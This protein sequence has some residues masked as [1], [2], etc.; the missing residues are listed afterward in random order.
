LVQ[1]LDLI[2]K[3]LDDNDTF[4]VFTSP[5]THEFKTIGIDL[6]RYLVNE[7]KSP[8]VY[9]CIDKPYSSIKRVL[10]KEEID[11]KIIIF[12]DTVTLMSGTQ[13]KD[14]KCV[15]I[16]SPENLTDIS[17]AI[18]QAI[19]SLSGNKTFIIV[20]S[21]S[22]LLVYNNIHTVLKFVHIINAKIK[23]YGAKGLAISA[24]KGA[25]DDF[26]NQVFQFFD[27]SVDVSGGG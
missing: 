8:V 7:K 13:P 6:L 24:K 21:L 25:D 22:T 12:I 14:D 20:D 4:L 10:D 17:I 9:I 18:S 2:R 19:S 1:V 11:S 16:R 27:D 23:Q 15:Y 3:K 5:K 26:I